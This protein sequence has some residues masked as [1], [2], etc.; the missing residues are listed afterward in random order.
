MK[1]AR[2]RPIG[3]KPATGF[4]SAL[5]NMEGGRLPFPEERAWLQKEAMDALMRANI[6]IQDAGGRLVITDM[7]RTPQEQLIEW[8]N[9]LMGRKTSYS[10]PPGAGMHEIG[11]AVDID[12]RSSATKIP[13][14][15]IIAALTASGWRSIARPGEPGHWHWEY[16]TKFLQNKMDAEGYAAMVALA[17]EQSKYAFP[18]E[19]GQDLAKMDPAQKNWL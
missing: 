2:A 14:D 11:R 16:R 17:F 15:H 10:P 6:A 5:L 9:W 13:P 4:M 3:L 12:L 7:W 18:I 8:N 1:Y 19:T